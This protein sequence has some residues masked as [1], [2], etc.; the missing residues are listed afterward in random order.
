ML[1]LFLLA[2][3]ALSV[4]SGD[5]SLN[6][7]ELSVVRAAQRAGVH[8]PHTESCLLENMKTLYIDDNEKLGKLTRLAVAGGEEEEG[9]GQGGG[10][11]P[12]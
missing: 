12:R 5:P 1:R 10:S 8:S 7:G 4:A 11:A 9:R 6:Q 2:A 3:S